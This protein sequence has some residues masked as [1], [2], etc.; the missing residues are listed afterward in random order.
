MKHFTT[1]L[2]LVAKKLW[3]PI[4]VLVTELGEHHGAGLV[5]TVAR[6][7]GEAFAAALVAGASP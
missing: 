3:H 2:S 4:E 5:Y 7:N 1:L 6:A